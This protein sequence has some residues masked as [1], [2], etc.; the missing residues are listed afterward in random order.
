MTMTIITMTATPTSSA[1]CTAFKCHA[2]RVQ[3]PRPAFNC[4]VHR[5]PRSSA[6]RPAFKCHVHHI[7]KYSAFFSIHKKSVNA[8]HFRRE[9]SCCGDGD[10]D[11]FI[12][13][14]FSSG[15]R[16]S[17]RQKLFKTSNGWPRQWRAKPTRIKA[18]AGP[19]NGW[20]LVGMHGRLCQQDCKREL[21]LTF[22][23]LFTRVSHPEQVWVRLQQREQ[24]ALLEFGQ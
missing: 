15:S 2:P 24:R 19:A 13:I 7:L 6:T 1:T 10:G 20:G 14:P 3:V 23:V 4:H 8:I 16:R 17:R 5:A 22:R 12:S 21:R 9:R 11:V 18:L